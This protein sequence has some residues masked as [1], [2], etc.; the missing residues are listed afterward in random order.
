[1]L[2]TLKVEGG[3]ILNGV[4]D[5]K[6]TGSYYGGNIYL[7]GHMI[8]SG[9]TIS[10]GLQGTTDYEIYIPGEKTQEVVISGGTVV[11][12]LRVNGP[13]S[14]T[15]EGAPKL[16]QLNL[17]STLIKVGELT[18]GAQ[19]V[20]VSNTEVFSE[21]CDKAQAYVD[22]GY[23]TAYDA[24]KTIAVNSG[25]ALTINVPKIIKW[26]DHC[27]QNVEWQEYAG[28]EVGSGYNGDN[29][30]LYLPEGGYT[31]SY[32]QIDIQGEVTLDLNGQT[33]TGKVDKRLWKIEGIFNIIDTVGGGVVASNNNPAGGGGIA[34]CRKNPNNGDKPV[35]N[36]YGGT[37]TCTDTAVP[38]SSS[39]IL[40]MNADTTLNMFGGEIKGGIAA[41][42]AQNVNVGGGTL[43]MTGGFIDG[44]ILAPADSEIN[45]SGSAKIAKTNDGLALASGVKINLDTMTD[46]EI[47]VSGEAAAFTDVLTNADEYLDNIKA[48]KEGWTVANV[49]G[50]LTLSDGRAP[51]D[52]NAVHALAAAMDFTTTDP[53][54][55]VTAECP[56]CRE[57][58]EW[59][60]LG[61]NTTGSAMVLES[62]HY[63]LS[64][65]TDY[66]ANNYQ[67]S[68][69][70]GKQVCI[71]LNGQT[72]TSTTRVLYTETKGNVVNIMGDGVVTGGGTPVSTGGYRGAVDMTATVNFYGG[73]WNSSNVEAPA[74]ENRASS[75][76]ES[77]VNIYAGTVVNSVDGGKAIQITKKGNLNICG[78]TVGTVFNNGSTGTVTVSGAPVISNL[79]L[80][81]GTMVEVGELTTGADITVTAEGVF[82]NSLADAAAMKGYFKAADAEKSIV[83]EG[84]AL[85]CVVESFDPNKVAEKAQAMSFATSDPDGKVEAECP[86][87]C[88]TVTWL[89]LPAVI[90]GNL[91]SKANADA[92]A[93]TVGFTNGAHHHYYLSENVDYTQN[94]GYYGV[95]ASTKM[96]LNLNG[97]NIVSPYRTFFTE[98]AATVL[99]IMGEGTVTGAGYTSGTIVRASMDCTAAVNLYGGIYVSSSDRPVIWMRSSS[100]TKCVLNVYEG[101]T[102]SAENAECAARVNNKSTI[103]VNGGT[104][105]GGVLNESANAVLSV[106]GTPVIDK[107]NVTNGALLTVGELA[108]GADITVITEGVFTNEIAN[109]AAAKPYFKSGVAGKTILIEGKTLALGEE[110]ELVCP[111]CGKTAA[112]LEAAGT[113]WTEWT[114]AYGST[115]KGTIQSG[116]YYMT[117]DV[118]GMN[119]YYYIGASTSDTLADRRDVVLDMRGFSLQSST[120]V[121]YT[122][123]NNDL[124]IFDS[125]GGSTITGGL[126]SS[127]GGTIFFGDGGNAAEGDESKLAIYN[128]SLIDGA[129]KTREKN[130]GVVFASGNASLCFE[131]VTITAKTAGDSGALAMS[132]GTAVMKD[133][134]INGGTVSGKGG[135]LCVTSTGTLTLENTTVVSGEAASAPGIYLA[136]GAT[137]NVIDG[138]VEDVF[139][140]TSETIVNVS[141]TAVIGNLDLSS[142]AK[143]ASV[144]LTTGADITVVADGVFTADLADAAA[145]KGFFKSGVA[146]KSV[147]IEGAALAIGVESTDPEQPEPTDKSI[148]EQAKEMD[149]TTTDA[150]GKVTAK[151]PVCNAEVEWLPMAVVEDANATKTDALKINDG[152]HHHFY[153]SES[154]DYT[155]NAGYYSVTG[156]TKV[157]LNLNG[158]TL[159]STERV[160]YTE[161]SGTVVNIMGEGTVTG[162]SII[163]ATNKNFCG[164]IDSTAG[165]NLYGGTWTS[166]TEYAVLSSRGSGAHCVVNMYEGTKLVRTAEGA[167]GNVVYVC[168][169]GEFNMYGGEIIGGSAVVQPNIH[170]TDAIGGN[171]IIRANA[172]NRSYTAD[173]NIYDGVISNTGENKGANIYLAGND[174][175]NPTAKANIC[176]GTIEGAGVY[177]TGANASV[178]VSGAPVVDFLDMVDANL[179]TVGELTEGASIKVAATKDV[180]F[181]GEIAANAETYAAFFG[182]DELKTGVVVKNNALVLT[183]VCPH[184]GVPMADITWTELRKNADNSAISME[185]SGHYRLAEDLDST[186]N[187]ITF[188]DGTSNPV[189][190]VVIDTAG[191]GITGG[192][193]GVY[194]NKNHTLTVFDSVGGSVITTHSTNTKLGGSA[195]YANSGSTV[196][197][198]D[199]TYIAG[200]GIQ[201]NGACISV[202]GTTAVMNIYSGTFNGN[203]NEK[204]G[205]TGGTVN[206]RGTLNI[207]GGTFNASTLTDGIGSGIYVHTSGNLSIYG[208]KVYGDLYVTETG[209]LTVGGTPE[210]NNVVM[211]AGAKLSFDED[212]ELTE[213]ADITVDA[214][215]EFTEANENAQA[216]LDAGYIKAAEGKGVTVTDNIMS[217]AAAVLTALLRKLASF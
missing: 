207:Y 201:G 82:T 168:D 185:T 197:L 174:G 117:A 51:F 211:A 100:N 115:T 71:N 76:T 20:V 120:R 18:E 110:A 102:I 153:L 129:T 88:E 137:L 171:I 150:D 165:V 72:L 39:G 193:R 19:I 28:N 155:K 139:A 36:I 15:I 118:T 45:L 138:N 107:L 85:A 195:L 128:V 180:A 23:F 8:I 164:I 167:Q 70:G 56:V 73:T 35:V 126:A 43:N 187:T 57:T 68:V 63:Y 188:K 106:S 24:E 84:T 78:G 29:L 75:H 169:N 154:V 182:S 48:A 46:A 86:V 203:V 11:G 170:E 17:R 89:P 30:H 162:A 113:P 189:V 2:P 104:I 14:L 38:A 12:K 40:N 159:T 121:F 156:G 131:G 198:Y 212:V 93:K 177:A 83:V 50:A 140:N 94:I 5:S 4:C 10:G 34:M 157:C 26:C 103:N 217:M 99:N 66:T 209:K 108:E 123:N 112:E 181:T 161:T 215:G 204:S 147:I 44:G 132:A 133:C 77:Y 124:T 80:S 134:T 41:S 95:S 109:A 213:G 199:V 3:Q 116:H 105:V 52:P 67:Y 79:D 1:M 144:E 194:V 208:G 145:A 96:C 62:G 178:T 130:G 136:G 101:T 54:G 200:E 202:Y 92:T 22:A 192:G 206:C 114:A 21:P 60:P 151:C 179:L 25:N 31:Q 158:Q 16:G 42:G 33:L 152:A 111:H 27:S 143:L 127:A 98:S 210:I 173:V 69:T 175:A 142:G 184:C 216:Y 55:K 7:A 53:D 135:A 47:Y 160:L 65:S 163:N 91:T 190:D 58:V 32:G 122:Y 119:G 205:V 90:E 191:F 74:I 59:L 6:A 37:L 64:A 183:D 186:G 97:Q 81:N 13:K 61:A 172:Q 125:V 141:G 9:G 214:A 148:Y 176:G 149:F 166:T 146:D 87:C 196:N 49:G